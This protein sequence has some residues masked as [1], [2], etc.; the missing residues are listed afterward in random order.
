MARE[1]EGEQAYAGG[2]SLFT[3]QTTRLTQEI[4]AYYQ[5]EIPTPDDTNQNVS[6]LLIGHNKQIMREFLNENSKDILT[7]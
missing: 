5:K 7:A 6:D 2:P 3:N 4:G 1:R